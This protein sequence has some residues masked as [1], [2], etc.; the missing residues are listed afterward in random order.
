MKKEC[1]KD[2]DPCDKKLDNTLLARAGIAGFEHAV[3]AETLGTWKSLSLFDLCG[4]KDGRVV[5]KAN[6]CK[7]PVIADTGYRWK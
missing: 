3:K 2:E 7:G 1:T 6:G 5:V 4:C